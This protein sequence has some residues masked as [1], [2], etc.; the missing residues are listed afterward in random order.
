VAVI[1]FFA[2]RLFI[3]PRSLRQSDAVPAPNISLPTLNRG[4]QFNLRQHRGK[5]V[6]LEFWAS[7]CA[8]CKA[9]LPMVE[10]F[11]RTHRGV[12]VEAVDVGESRA[13][14]AEFART[15]GMENVALDNNHLAANWFD[16]AGFPT[17]IVVDSRGMIRAKWAGFN[18]ALT[19]NMAHAEAE[20]RS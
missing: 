19:F 1:V 3:A 5:V 10:R 9:S 13:V 20:L 17:M 11:A 16:V 2:Y 12:Y 8:P 7:W 6:F 18:P 4:L 15:H 14:A